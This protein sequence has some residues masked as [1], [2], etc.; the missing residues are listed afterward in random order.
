M[1]IQF[2]LG[3]AFA[4]CLSLFIHQHCSAN[5]IQE[6]RYSDYFQPPNSFLSPFGARSKPNK[7]TV[8]EAAID[9]RR[10]T[11]APTFF[12]GAIRNGQGVNRKVFYIFAPKLYCPDINQDEFWVYVADKNS[13]IEA[14][15]KYS[16][17][18]NISLIP[19]YIETVPLPRCDQ[20]LSTRLIKAPQFSKPSVEL[21]EAAN[22]Y[23]KCHLTQ[24]IFY[25][26]AKFLKTKTETKIALD[27]DDTSATD[28]P[29]AFIVDEGRN[30]IES[31]E[32]YGRV[33][34]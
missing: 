8:K 13:K 20:D 23:A 9:V 14:V 34:K 2:T 33:D 29:V 6:R 30:K 22:V 31:F 18:L 15:F 26:G 17:D 32:P 10:R 16:R 5:E 7:A 25:W 28:I 21:I 1:R 24:N 11:S 27:F 19:L 12:H 4:A 3:A